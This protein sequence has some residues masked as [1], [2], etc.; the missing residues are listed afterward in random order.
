[1]KDIL[2]KCKNLFVKV[3]EKMSYFFN[4]IT[5]LFF[6]F[7]KRFDVWIYL[8]IITS[9]SLL[10]RY[11]LLD[12]IRG[13]FTSFLKP[14]YKRILENGFSAIGV[15]FGDYTPAYYYLLYFLSLF[16]FDPE[17]LSVLH[18]IKWISIFFDYLLAVFVSLIC[19]ELTKNKVKML[20]AYTATVF[21]LTIFLNSSLWGQCDAIYSSFAVISIYCI[22]KGKPN[23]SMIFLGFS[24]SFKLQT[25]F[26]L[27][28]FIIMF[29]RR[30]FK[31]RYF[32]WIPLIYCLMAIPACFASDNFFGRF[33]EILRIYINQS[34]NSYQQLTLNAGSFYALIFT[35]FKN[36]NF[37]SSFSLYL[38][39]AIIGTFIFFIYRSKEKFNRNTWFK[40]FVLFAMIMPYFLPHMHE[41]Y[42]YIADAIVVV[43]ALINPKKFYIAIM[44]IL[45][46]MIGYMVY[47]WNVSFINVVP[48]DT[49]ADSTKALSFRFGSMVYLVAI[50]IVSVDLFKELY[51]KGLSNE[52][53][54]VSQPK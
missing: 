25:I 12:C 19:L 42:F 34:T 32:L 4:K 49:A 14:W 6:T 26:I 45:N 31:L 5:E 8:F 3:K 24:F 41:R 53:E 38:A 51:P 28:V 7:L 40:I 27:P 2:I 43:Y 11:F 22:L 15:S 17:S 54:T 36:E 30:E 33:N 20:I 48:Q 52:E 39:I 50:I 44:A 29:L 37:I 1:M 10:M 13:D 21:G 47:L 35:N 16:K 18:G 9:L 23:L 46:S